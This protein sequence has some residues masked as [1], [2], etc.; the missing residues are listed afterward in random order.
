MARAR[1]RGDG[2]THVHKRA[3]RHRSYP[4]N[5][6][7]RSALRTRAA[8]DVQTRGTLGEPQGRVYLDPCRRFITSEVAGVT[9]SPLRRIHDEKQTWNGCAVVG[10]R[11][12]VCDRVGSSSRLSSSPSM[13]R[14]WMCISL[15]DRLLNR[16]QRRRR[17]AGRC[18]SRPR[19]ACPSGSG[20][21]SPEA[22]R[23]SPGS[24]QGAPGR[25]RDRG[26]L[27]HDVLSPDAVGADA[28][29][30]ITISAIPPV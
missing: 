17:R 23:A 5:V 16:L 20:P 2:S 22:E 29:V 8:Q 21:S 25:R 11:R 6:D 24:G 4:S 19:G 18:P 3:P 9:F 14:W 10:C 13:R 30:R 15:L 7:E 27:D 28:I 1:A 12:L 26:A